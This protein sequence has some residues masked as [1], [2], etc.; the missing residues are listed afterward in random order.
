MIGAQ[1]KKHPTAFGLFLASVPLTWFDAQQGDH[2]GFAIFA[3]ICLV[4]LFYT[5][6]KE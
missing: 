5:L 2:M 3:T 4:S 6:F 1:I